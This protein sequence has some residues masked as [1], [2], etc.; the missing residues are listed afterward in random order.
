VT[1]Y[2]LHI[3]PPY[4]H[5]KHYVGYTPAKDVTKRVQEHLKGGD[6]G[7]PLIRYAMEAG[8]TVTLATTME[9][10]RDEERRIK[11]WHKTSQLCPICKR[12]K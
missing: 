9:G 10:G 6:R 3:E 4:R 7:S 1:V 8:C 12:R 2:I 11:R 5:A